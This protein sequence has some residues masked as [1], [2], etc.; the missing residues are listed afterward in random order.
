M[1]LGTIGLC[2]V[3]KEIEGRSKTSLDS[4]EK[5]C[6]VMSKHDWE[7][8]NT[9]GYLNFDWRCGQCEKA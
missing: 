7:Y 4:E 5:E 3:I 6:Q 9:Q 2:K 1:V 8:V